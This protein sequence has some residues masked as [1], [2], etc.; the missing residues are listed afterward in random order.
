MPD[1]AFQFTSPGYTACLAAGLLLSAFYWSRRARGNPRLSLVWVG[2]LVGALAGAKLGFILAE[3]PLWWNDPHFLERMLVGKTVLGALLGGFIGVE[4]VKKLTGH[5]EAT[6]DLFAGIIPFG[7]ALGRVGCVMHGCCQGVCVSQAAWWTLKDAEGHPHYPAPLVELAF[8]LAAG[9]LIWLCIRKGWQ[10]GQLFHLYLMGYG[11]FRFGHEFVRDTPHYPG[12]WVSP[13]MPLALALVA[14]G[15]V[16]YGMRRKR[17]VT[18][19]PAS[20]TPQ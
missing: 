3:A 10:K 12:T 15:A 16:G 9:G 14:A 17:Q 13:Y 20:H 2:G 8:N 19:L 1:H 18:P 4:A 11:A 7:I 5:R 6:G